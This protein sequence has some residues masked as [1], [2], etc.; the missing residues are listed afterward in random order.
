LLP[1]P[2]SANSM[3]MAPPRSRLMQSNVF[4]TDD[5]QI[6]WGLCILSIAVIGVFAYRRGWHKTPTWLRLYIWCAVVV[7]GPLW[8]MTGYFEAERA[9]K[10]GPMISDAGL[11]AYAHERDRRVRAPIGGLVGQFESVR[12]RER[13]HTERM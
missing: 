11:L 7:E 12:N 9:G 13:L 10:A 6:G 2:R 5:G 4:T 8:L 3:S 1:T